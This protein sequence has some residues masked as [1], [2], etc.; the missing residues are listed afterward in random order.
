MDKSSLDSNYANTGFNQRLGFGKKP[1]VVL[2][3]PVQAYFTE[4]SPVYH[5][6]FRPSLDASIRLVQAARKARVPVAITNMDVQRGGVGGGIFFEKLS[7]C[8]ACFEP[9][10]PLGEFPPELVIDSTDIIISKRYPSAFFGTGL[11]SALTAM[12]V[13]TVLLCGVSTSGCVRASCVDAISHGFRPA[14][15]RD[16]V[17]DRHPAVHEANLYDMNAKYAD[18]IGEGEAMAYLKQVSLA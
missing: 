10:N 18:V 11:A 16:A 13:D 3:D 1:A 15:V 2:I 6:L 5:P 12:G 4:G 14:V 7:H 8:L 17:G 9:G